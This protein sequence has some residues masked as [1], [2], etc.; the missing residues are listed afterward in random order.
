MDLSQLPESARRRAQSAARHLF[1]A[2]IISGPEGCG[3]ERLAEWLA[4]ACVCS[5]A[6][7]VPC[8]TCPNCR[9]AAGNIHPDIIR[10]NVPEGKRGISVEQVRQLRADAYIRP[11]EAPRKVFLIEDAQA[12]N[13]SAQNA[14][15]KVLEDGPA[16]LT[17]LLLAEN[18][19]QLLSTIRSRCELISLA[20]GED[21]ALKERDPELEQTARELAALLVRG[22]AMPLAEYTAAME[23][24]KWDKDALLELFD[25]LEDALRPELTARPDRA[26]P[27][28]ERLRKARQAARF[29]VGAGHLFGLLSAGE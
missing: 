14:L 26:L 1:H 21:G 4:A 2:Y 27:V 11:N 20:P 7:E 13:D 3:K 15:L 19:L 8:L 12:M 24:K 6:G 29:N 5:G 22:E 18:P 10:V 16:Y 23:G 28:I 17:F 25:A 9:K